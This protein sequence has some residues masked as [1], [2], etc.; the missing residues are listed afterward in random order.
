MK[1]NIKNEYSVLKKV[2]IAPTTQEYIN[3][4]KQ[5]IEILNKYNVKIIM[6]KE[7]KDAKYQMFI[8]D[9]FIV[10]GEK[11]IIC[12]MKEDFRKKEVNAIDGLLKTIDDSKK[13]KLKENIII[14]GGD[15]II[16]NGVI[17]VGQNGN[18]TNKEGLDFLKRTFPQYKVIS[19][20]MIN[21][22][23]NMPWIH[24]DCL[25]N[26][27]NFDTAIVYKDGFDKKSFNILKENFSNLIFLSKEEQDE[28]AT[29][30]FNLGNKTVIMQKRH[31]RL[32]K[33]IKSLG[34]NVE[35]MDIYD[36][37]YETGYNRC[38]TCPIE[39]I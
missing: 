18:R 16:H 33:E 29:N 6:A 1:L 14:E 22:N 21:P 30:V 34:F 10:I 13:I 8:R 7:C 17:F 35:I 5:L 37:I 26:P 19:L 11:I 20:N 32:I 3:Q 38:M 15:V 9:P 23:N 2:L 24:L 27:I 25:F 4:Q 12:S 31:E 28:L 39:R 36:T